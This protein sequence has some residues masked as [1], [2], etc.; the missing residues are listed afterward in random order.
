HGTRSA[1]AGLRR[2]FPLPVPTSTEVSSRFVSLVSSP[3]A[4]KTARPERRSCPEQALR[5]GGLGSCRF[6]N[7]GIGGAASVVPLTTRARVRTDCGAALK[8]APPGQLAPSARRERRFGRWIGV[9]ASF[10][11]SGSRRASPPK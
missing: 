11:R 10:R 1:R 3:P 4:E 6:W 7:C 9:L 8:T 2:W 5:D